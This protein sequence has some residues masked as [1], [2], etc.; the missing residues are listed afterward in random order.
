MEGIVSNK[1][2]HLETPFRDLIAS[3]PKITKQATA[4]DLKIARKILETEDTPILA[5]ALK[6]RAEFLITLDKRFARL[7]KEKIPMTILLPGDYVALWR[8][9]HGG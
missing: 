9:Q 2:P 5:G 1:F 4:G 8:K 6:S 3:K 7:V